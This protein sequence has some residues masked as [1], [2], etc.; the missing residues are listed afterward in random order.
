MPLK[1]LFKKFLMNLCLIY[2]NKIKVLLYRE[3]ILSMKNRNYSIIVNIDLVFKTNYNCNL[4]HLKKLILDTIVVLIM[5]LNCIFPRT[6]LKI[7]I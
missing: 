3:I 4:H 2:L 1:L 7:N 5:V 6:L